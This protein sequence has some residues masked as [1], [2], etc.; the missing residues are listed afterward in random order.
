MICFHHFQP[1]PRYSHLTEV[2]LCKCV[3]YKMCILMY[4][5]SVVQADLPVTLSSIFAIKKTPASVVSVDL[6][7]F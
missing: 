4:L 3:L 2:T 5:F 6:G 1:V 7:C